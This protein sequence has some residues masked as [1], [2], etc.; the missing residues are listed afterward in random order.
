VRLAIVGSTQFA[1]DEP[2][3]VKAALL[4][5]KVITREEPD[6]VISGGAPGIDSL[7]A[8]TAAEMGV[9]VTEHLPQHKR[10]EPDGFKARNL[11]IAQD[12]THL[13]A[14]R[15]PDSTTYGSGWTADCA[16]RMGKRVRRVEIP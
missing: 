2:A 14:I 10:W 9:P 7:A 5:R 16:E 1:D 11:L 8:M 15:H 3:A 13:L 4:I 12:C 6:V